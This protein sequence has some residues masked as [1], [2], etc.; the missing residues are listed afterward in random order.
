MAVVLVFPEDGEVVP[1]FLDWAARLQIRDKEEEKLLHVTG[2]FAQTSLDLP[3]D[4]DFVVH[5]E[6][7]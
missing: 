3:L 1:G 7:I 2:K 4:S 5:G 6:I